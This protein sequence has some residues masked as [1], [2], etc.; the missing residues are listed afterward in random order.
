VRENFRQE[1]KM[2]VTRRT[3]TYA[4]PLMVLCLMICA[5]AQTPD[6]QNSK[7]IPAGS[8]VYIAPMDGF[9]TFL[10]AALEEKK[11]PLV[12]V[13][14]KETADFEITGASSS[15]KASAAKKVFTLSW[16][17]KEEASINVANIKTG[18]VVFAYSAHKQ[19]SAHGKRSSAEACA[20]HLKEKVTRK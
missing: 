6:S 14:D 1:N 9:E 5:E 15:Q 10:K 17:S 19:N 16:H 4:A 8:K 11:V 13:E 12:V 20:K 7:A 2:T 3:V 18:E